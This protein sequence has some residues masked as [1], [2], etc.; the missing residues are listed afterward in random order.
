MDRVRD[1]RRHADH[2]AWRG[3]HQCSG[4]REVEGA[5]KDEHQRIGGAFDAR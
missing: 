2:C 1:I 5:V 4:D 3:T